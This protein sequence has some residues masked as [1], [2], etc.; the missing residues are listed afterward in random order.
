MKKWTKINNQNWKLETN[1]RW[2][3][4]YELLK[5]FSEIDQEKE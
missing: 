3:L 1:T 2:E 5:V 4:M